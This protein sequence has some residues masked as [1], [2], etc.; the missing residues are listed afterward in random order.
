MAKLITVPCPQPSILWSPN[1]PSYYIYTQFT[2]VSCDLHEE[3]KKLWEAWSHPCKVTWLIDM[4]NIDNLA[5]CWWWRPRKYFLTLPFNLQH[6]TQKGNLGLKRTIK[7]W[8][9]V[10]CRKCGECHLIK[11]HFFLWWIFTLLWTPGWPGQVNTSCHQM[12]NKFR[13]LWMCFVLQLYDSG[14]FHRS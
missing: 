10:G 1:N 5:P 13:E 11:C 8:G 7:Y 14:I 6:L 3:W 9:R 4:V 12:A 2:V